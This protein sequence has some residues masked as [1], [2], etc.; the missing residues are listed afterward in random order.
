MRHT[1][2]FR[3]RHSV[4]II[5]FHT[6]YR[7]PLSLSAGETLAVHLPKAKVPF[8]AWNLILSGRDCHAIARKIENMRMVA[9]YAAE[10]V[11]DVVNETSD[12]MAKIAGNFGAGWIPAENWPKN[13]GTTTVTL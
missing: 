6:V 10:A 2:L 13:N 7:K 1:C 4:N 5:L 11:S 8:E 12:S 9:G 3:R